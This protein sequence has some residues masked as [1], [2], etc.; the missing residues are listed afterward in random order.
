[1]KEIWLLLTGRVVQMNH[2][3]YSDRLCQY[4]ANIQIITHKNQPLKTKHYHDE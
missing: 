4:T 1:M 2:C 3:A